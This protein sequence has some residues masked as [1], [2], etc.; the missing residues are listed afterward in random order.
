MMTAVYNYFI[1]VTFILIFSAGIFPLQAQESRETVYLSI[2]EHLAEAFPSDSVFIGATFGFRLLG[3]EVE[4]TFL[5]EFTYCTPENEIKQRVV[6][7]E[8]EVWNW[9]PIDAFI[10]WAEKNDITLRLHGPIGP[11]C[12]VWA[13]EDHRTARE[14]EMNMTEFMTAVCKRFNGHKNV[15]WLDVVNETVQ[16]DGSWHG[17]LPGVGGWE[18]PWLKMGYHNDPSHTPLYIIKAFEIAGKYAPDIKLIYNHNHQLQEPMWEKVKSTVLYLRSLGLR[19]DGI[20]WQAHLKSDEP[21]FNDPEKLAFLSS[22]IEWAHNQKLEFHITEIDCN[23]KDLSENEL[24]LQAQAYANILNVLLAHR[25]TGVVGFNSWGITDKFGPK[26]G[27]NPYMFDINL[28]PKPA[29][30][31]IQKVLEQ[32]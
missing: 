10:S 21:I 2:K 5:R 24:A 19:V 31:A 13:E 15:R 12:S 6:H 7:P 28:Q 23:I 20:G 3:S 27:K 4:K 18:N 11:Q 8:P 29:Y 32:K 14:L 9:E 17:P 1:R 22:L 25:H 26:P 16:K 30:F